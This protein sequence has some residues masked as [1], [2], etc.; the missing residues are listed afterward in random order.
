MEP[1][2]T[3]RDRAACGRRGTRT[4]RR[5]AGDSLVGVSEFEIRTLTDATADA[6]SECI[7][8]AFHERTPEEVRTA[9]RRLLPYERTAVAFDADRLVGT[10]GVF[11]QRLSVPGGELPCA[12][13]TVVT[14]LPTHRRRGVL[15]RMMARLFEQAIDAGEPI[16]ALWAAEGGIY[17]RF[18]YGVAAQTMTLELDGGS[19]PPP[20]DGAAGLRVELLPLDGA[21][22]LLN[23]V[24]ERVR[25]QR[26]GVP[27]RSAGWWAAQ[28]LADPEEKRDQ[29]RPKRLVVARDDTGSVQGYALYRARGP[30]EATVL[31]VQELIAPD[32]DAEAALWGYFCGVDL[33]TTVEASLRPVDDPLPFRLA[34]FRQARVVGVEDGLWVRLLDVPAALAGRAWSAAADVTFALS[35]ARL[36]ANAGTWRLEA[37]AEGDGRCTRSD[38]DPELA[39]DIA[40]LGAAYLGGTPLARLADAGRVRELAPGALD[41]L[42][43]ALRTP[44]APWIPEHF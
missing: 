31:D 17:G 33:V 41:R 3:G 43:R 44:R 14:V 30:E 35:D 10:S 39:L 34:D 38:R 12:G 29:G 26:A 6:F 1:W 22:S 23:P 37:S 36:P 20:H 21:A 19:T 5:A 7:D 27:A 9:F 40:A 24:W 32:P 42:D 16:A 25:A 28:P 2:G 8:V 13:V 18:G 11:P 4:V 15:T